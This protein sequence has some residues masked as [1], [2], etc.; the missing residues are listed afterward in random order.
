ML[1]V[2]RQAKARKRE[3]RKRHEEIKRWKR[4]RKIQRKKEREENYYE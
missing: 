4:E 3:T 1:L 2:N